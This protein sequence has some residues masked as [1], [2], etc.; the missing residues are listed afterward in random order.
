M[1]G[2]TATNEGQGRN[3][4]GPGDECRPLADVSGAEGDLVL[5]GVRPASDVG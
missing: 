2:T 5:I 3:A 1:T 4:V